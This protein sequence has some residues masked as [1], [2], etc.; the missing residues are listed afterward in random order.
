MEVK[1][2]KIKD[3][4]Y[5]F[6]SVVGKHSVLIHLRALPRISDTGVG[7]NTVLT[8]PDVFYRVSSKSILIK[9]ERG[10][11]SLK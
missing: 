1:M 6:C 10:L 11:G 4:E 5:Y 9:F 7:G 2:E 3:A 8:I